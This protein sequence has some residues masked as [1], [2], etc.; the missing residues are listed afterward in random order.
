M[1]VLFNRAREACCCADT[2]LLQGAGGAIGDGWER[3]CGAKGDDVQLTAEDAA[4]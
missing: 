1:P 2:P 3:G 4:P